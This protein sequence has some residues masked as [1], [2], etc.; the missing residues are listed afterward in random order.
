MFGFACLYT[1]IK[2]TRTSPF[3]DNIWKFEDGP[4]VIAIC[5]V[6]QMYYTVHVVNLLKYIPTIRLW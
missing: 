1:Q 2:N 4:L 5:V 6:K 3:A